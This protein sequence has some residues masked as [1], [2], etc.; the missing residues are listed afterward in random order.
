MKREVDYGVYLVTDRPLCGDRPLE[1]VVLAAVCGGA[2]VV[3]LR[4]K[5]CTTRAFVELAAALVIRLRPVGVP[6]IIND[7]VDVALA[8]G[9]DGVHV[10][11]SDMP[12]AKARRLMG[13]EAIVGLSVETPEQATDAEDLDCDY[14]GVSPIFSTPTKTDTYAEWGLAGLRALRARSRHKLVAIGGL[15][16]GNAT[17]VV[18]AGADGIAVVSA[19]CAAEDPEAAARALRR[20]VDAGRRGAGD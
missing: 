15:H 6:L 4:E 19:I 9:A 11:Q 16:P 20:I 18:V 3:Q 13:P 10:G 17:E 8:A 1:E 2:T 7:R 12:S 5:D 14:L